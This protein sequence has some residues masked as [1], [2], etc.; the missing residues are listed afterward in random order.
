[1]FA[2]DNI[3]EIFFTFLILT[4]SSVQYKLSSIALVLLCVCNT[5][6]CAMFAWHQNTRYKWSMLT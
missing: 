1:M 5:N 6:M 2:E 3:Q 4:Q